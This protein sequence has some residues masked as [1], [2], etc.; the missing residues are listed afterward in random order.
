MPNFLQERTKL[1]YCEIGNIF[2]IPTKYKRVI[3]KFGIGCIKED[4]FF[5]AVP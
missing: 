4:Y 2:S 3:Q 5:I 1:P